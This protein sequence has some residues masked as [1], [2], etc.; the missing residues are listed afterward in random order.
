[1][2]KA[3][4][5]TSLSL[6]VIVSTLYICVLG[7]NNAL[8]LD[9]YGYVALVE[10]YG[11]LGLIK[12]TYQ[13]WQC[14]FSTFFVNGIFWSLFGHS[15]NLIGVT[16]I[17]LV[18]GWWIM[19]RLFSGINRFYDLRISNYFLILL[20]ILT[21]NVGV[22]A[23][24]EPSTFYWLSTLNYTISVWITLL[25]VSSLFFSN[26]GSFIR[27][28]SVVLCSLYLGGTAEN[29]TPLIILVLGI[30][31]VIRVF[32]KER[33]SSS[34]ENTNWLLF[35]SLFIM[36]VG[37]LVMLL[38]PGNKN[39]L[40]DGGKDAIALANLTISSLFLRTIK[41]SF[42]IL[43]RELSRVHFFLLMFLV[44][45]GI[46]T[47]CRC[48][49][50]SKISFGQTVSVIL[51]LVLFILVA[52]AVCVAG[53]GWSAPLRAFSFLSFV[54]L[55]VCA[56]LG[57]RL[58]ILVRRKEEVRLA[59]VAVS[60]IGALFFAIRIVRDVP[61]VEEYHEYVDNRNLGIEMKK[62]A[63][64][65]GDDVETIP[66][67]CE[68]FSSHWRINSYSVLRNA[69]NQ[70]IGKTKRYAEPQML[71]MESSLGNNADDWR[72]RDLQSYY[73]VGFDIVCKEVQ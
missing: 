36:C 12:I 71:L 68:P 42:I 33:E 23:Y 35:A 26:S 67:F 60:L 66:F 40:A 21:V 38:G 70:I 62:H 56:F 29:Y 10:D 4:Y 17:M 7:W 51:L 30:I 45:L 72:N 1:M 54:I 32:H 9:D 49:R 43:L 20:A 3:I 31:W 11:L 24:L 37:F 28:I 22:M 16:L 19:E 50:V 59:L 52:V 41:A 6:A 44:F 69:I 18:S 48:D 2:R 39:R 53:I 61:L 27:W 47:F 58:G 65:M 46:G 55:A 5:S 34:R 63:V 25:L 14:R 57:I 73:R 64:E 8:A 13:G 15:D